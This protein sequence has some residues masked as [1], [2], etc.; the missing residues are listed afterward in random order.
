MRIDM[1]E[2][3]NLEQPIVIQSIDEGKLMQVR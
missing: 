3:V 2:Q 1:L